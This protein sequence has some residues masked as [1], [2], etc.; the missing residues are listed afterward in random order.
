[1]VKI[2]ALAPDFKLEGY[3]NDKIKDFSLKDYKG[4]WIVLFF[5]PLDFTFVCPTE[6]TEFSKRYS[7]FKKVNAEVLGVSVDSVYSHKDWVEK[8]GGLKYPL[9][10]DFKKEA[11]RNYE[12]LVEE[13][14]FALRATFI[15][16]PDGVFKYF[17]MSDVSVGRSVSEILRILNALQTGKLC[18]VEWKPGEK[19]L[20]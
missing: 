5:Y 12:V 17:V 2:G 8:I 18:P 7:E 9:L 13:K 11:S 14:G 3:Y 10:S 20:N 4:K 6:V 19:T 1:M 15:I 16:D